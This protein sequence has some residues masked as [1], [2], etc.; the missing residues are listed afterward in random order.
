M[1]A[2]HVVIAAG[3]LQ[4][5]QL[6]GMVLGQRLLGWKSELA[7]LE[8]VSRRLVTA[9]A[10]GIVLYV[11]GTGFIAIC[12]PFAV[13]TT[14]LGTSLCFLQMVAWSARVAQQGLL[15]GPVWPS[16]ARWLHRALLTVYGT[17]A[18]SYGWVFAGA[19]A[20]GG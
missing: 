19:Y 14:R 15:I 3:M 20:S 16:A 5:L 17:L 12:M 2:R 6:P 13:A 18:L 8:L 9:M 10:T 4:L 7:R 11:V 1:D